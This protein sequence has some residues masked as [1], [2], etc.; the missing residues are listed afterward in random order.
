MNFVI[1]THQHWCCNDAA[2]KPSFTQAL[3]RHSAEQTLILAQTARTRQ[4]NHP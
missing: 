3:Y 1:H 2:A 4:T